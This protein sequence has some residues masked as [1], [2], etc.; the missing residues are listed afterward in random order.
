MIKPLNDYIVVTIIDENKDEV[1]GLIVPD[2]AKAKPNK[3]KV[4]SVSDGAKKVIKEGDVVIWPT[5]LGVNMTIEGQKVVVL[6]LED[7]MVK[8]SGE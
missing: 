4:I 1:N 5:L 6:K 2:T 8:L 7:I 3:G